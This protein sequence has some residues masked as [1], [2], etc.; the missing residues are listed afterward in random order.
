MASRAPSPTGMDYYKSSRDQDLR[1]A[2]VDNQGIISRH[3][4]FEAPERHEVNNSAGLPQDMEEYNEVFNSGNMAFRAPSPGPMNQ[5]KSSKAQWNLRRALVGNQG[6]TRHAA[7]E[8]LSCAGFTNNSA[9]SSNSMEEDNQVFN[10]GNKTTASDSYRPRN[11]VSF[12]RTGESSTSTGANTI[13]KYRPSYS[14][15]KFSSRRN[16]DVSNEVIGRVC[17]K[18]TRPS[19][20]APASVNPEERKKQKPAIEPVSTIKKKKN[21][22]IEVIDLTHIPLSEV[23]EE[24][25]QLAVILDKSTYYH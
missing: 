14:K 6:N 1:P 17:Y 7:F 25:E 20:P 22:E 10:S 2:R 16:L 9:S 23:E 5:Y 21:K 13:D 12:T 19:G 3:A 8:A 24:R 11:A 18:Q 15:R 4:V